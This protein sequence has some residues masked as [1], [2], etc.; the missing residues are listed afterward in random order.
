[1]S[2]HRLVL[3]LGLDPENSICGCIAICVTLVCALLEAKVYW[4]QNSRMEDE[5][6]QKNIAYTASGCKVDDVDH[7]HWC[8]L[9]QPREKKYL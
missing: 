4:S 6:N 3:E 8:C 7:E 2:A 9:Q 5:K 1:M